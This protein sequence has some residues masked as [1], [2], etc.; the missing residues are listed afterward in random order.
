MQVRAKRRGEERPQPPDPAMGGELRWSQTARARH[1]VH[2]GDAR[3]AH[4]CCR[5]QESHTGE[6]NINYR[7]SG[8]RQ[9]FRRGR[10]MAANS[11]RYECSP[12]LVKLAKRQTDEK[13]AWI[14]EHLYELLESGA[15]MFPSLARVP[16]LKN[17]FRRDVFD[18]A[19]RVVAN[20]LNLSEFNGDP[21]QAKPSANGPESGL[22]SVSSL[23]PTRQG[24][25][26][27]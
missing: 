12:L 23:F 15:T 1:A 22:D 2:Q 20:E 27:T 11:T 3:R 24:G 5:R 16:V 18:R 14:I 7:A 25:N 8:K 9:L 17:V 21:A 26:R 13:A 19:R 10:G 6:E 4:R